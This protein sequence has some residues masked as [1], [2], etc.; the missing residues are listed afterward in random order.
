MRAD[1]PRGRRLPRSW[2]CAAIP[3]LAL[4][5]GT[6]AAFAAEK[7]RE[8][9]NIL[10]LIGEDLGT[11][12]GC[13]GDPDARTPHLDKL[14]SEGRMYRRA[15][16]TGSVCSPSRSAFCT[17]MYQTAIDAQHHRSHRH[18]HHRLPAGVRLISDR[19]REAGY[20][21]ANVRRFPDEVGLSGTGKTDWNFQP[22]GKPYDSDR[23]K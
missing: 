22:D 21:T 7:P 10:W 19:L 23:W 9:P 1:D 12:L 8:K 2:T 6:A 3:L 16:A 18:D 15:Y 5:L 4:H 20:F 14:A 11:D 13:Y 17:G